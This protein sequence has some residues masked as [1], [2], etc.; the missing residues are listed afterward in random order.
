MAEL[1]PRH[2][3]GDPQICKTSFGVECKLLWIWENKSQLS[4]QELKK[5]LKPY[6]IWTNKYLIQFP[7]YNKASLKV[8]TIST[9]NILLS[10][11]F[12]KN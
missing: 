9:E 8:P 1:D 3:E 10:R 2:E 4:E 7:Y 6:N 5:K 11:N 12:M